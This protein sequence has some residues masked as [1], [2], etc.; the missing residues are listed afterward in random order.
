[1]DIYKN[2]FISH[3]GEDDEH[4]QNLK[5]QLADRGCQ[6]RNS[7]ADSTRPNDLTEESEIKSMLRESIAWAGTFICLIGYETYDREWVEWE[8]E[9][10]H[11]M[12]KKIIGVFAYGAAADA[13]IPEGL[14]KYRDSIV[15][16]RIDNIID[17]LE[18]DTYYSEKPDGSSMPPVTGLPRI[19]C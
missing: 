5:T 2:V 13:E 15:G 16:W 4:V 19:D 3:H 8:I 6:L 7:S 18:N 17:A 12:G 14:E 9:Q 11:R 1:M 10:A